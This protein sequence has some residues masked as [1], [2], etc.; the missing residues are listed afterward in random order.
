[1]TIK[2]DYLESPTVSE[3]K[4]YIKRFISDFITDESNR[5]VDEIFEDEAK[6]YYLIK[7]INSDKNYNIPLHDQEKSIIWTTP[8][9]QVI[10][11]EEDVT[12]DP[13]KYIIENIKHQIVSWYNRRIEG[14]KTNKPSSSVNEDKE[15]AEYERLK[16]KFE[17]Q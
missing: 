6:L 17:N 15:R 16:K 14:T 13:E 8:I 9:M 7:S 2:S 1:M 12:F 11:D 3:L 10:D 4:A 5:L